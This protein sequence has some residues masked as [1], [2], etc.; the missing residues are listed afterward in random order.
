ME[1]NYEV[2]TLHR[3]AEFKFL[4]LIAI[5]QVKKMRIIQATEYGIY[6]IQASTVCK[7][8][9]SALLSCHYKRPYIR[10]QGF[11]LHQI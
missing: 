10:P 4:I 3:T 11:C 6:L 8:T 5:I 2:Y 9:K 1:E 7:C